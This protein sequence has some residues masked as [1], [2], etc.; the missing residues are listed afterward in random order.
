M[1]A[2]ADEEANEATAMTGATR[3]AVKRT[4]S[5]ITALGLGLQLGHLLAA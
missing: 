4:G 3:E 5:G 2:E 1:A